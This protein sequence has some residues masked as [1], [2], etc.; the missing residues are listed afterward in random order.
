MINC[1]HNDNFN[2]RFLNERLF[3]DIFENGTI[4]NDTR[5]MFVLCEHPI[6]ER[7]WMP[8]KIPI[9]SAIAR[10]LTAMGETDESDVC[11]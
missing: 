1:I 7:T 5:G 11:A 2:T 4:H 3:T 6:Y 9:D 10:E 8:I